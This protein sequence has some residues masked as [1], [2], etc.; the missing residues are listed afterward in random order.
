MK[1]MVFSMLGEMVEDRFGYD[2]WDDLIEMT[3]PASDGVYVSTELYPDEELT[4]YVA[5]MSRS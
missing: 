4:A 5:A 3:Q 1:G 2:M